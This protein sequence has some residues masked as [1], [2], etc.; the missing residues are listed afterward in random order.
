MIGPTFPTFPLPLPPRTMV[1]MGMPRD[2]AKTPITNTKG[3]KYLGLQK[4]VR[5]HAEKICKDWF[6]PG[7]ENLR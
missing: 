5:F 3:P 2:M 1:A 4:T 7:V 6:P